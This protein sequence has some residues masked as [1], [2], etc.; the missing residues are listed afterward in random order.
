MKKIQEQWQS[1]IAEK[2]TTKQEIKCLISWI[3]Y[4]DFTLRTTKKVYWSIILKSMKPEN[5]DG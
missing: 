3:I 5:D 2:M 4:M 1:F